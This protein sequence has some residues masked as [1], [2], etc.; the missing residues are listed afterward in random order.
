VELIVLELDDGERAVL[1]DEFTHE[2]GVGIERIAADQFAV[3]GARGQTVH[4]R[5]RE[6][7]FVAGSTAGELREGFTGGGIA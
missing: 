3:E 1:L 7:F 6:G 4:Q 5:M 2:C